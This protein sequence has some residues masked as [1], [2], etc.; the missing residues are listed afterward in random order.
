MKL[1]YVSDIDTTSSRE[2]IPASW[3]P[4]RLPGQASPAGMHDRYGGRR[5]RPKRWHDDFVMVILGKRT[6]KTIDDD[7]DDDDDGEGDVPL[8]ASGMPPTMRLVDGC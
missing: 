4:R 7:D 6:K 3:F 1:A 5:W 8:W 2:L